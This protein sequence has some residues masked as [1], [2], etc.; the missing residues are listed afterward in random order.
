MMRIRNKTFQFSGICG[1]N[2]LA[3]DHSGRL[4]TRKKSLTNKTAMHLAGFTLRHLHTAE[5]RFAVVKA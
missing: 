4:G 1:A 3:F 2:R 5:R